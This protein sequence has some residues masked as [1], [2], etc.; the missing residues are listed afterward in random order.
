MEVKIG[1]LVRP[2]DPSDPEWVC[3]FI[4]ILV[5]IKERTVNSNYTTWVVYEY[6]RQIY[7]T[8]DEPYWRLE[9]VT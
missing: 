3:P 7:A 9:K 5:D 2:Y 6:K 8:Y 1:D 4:G